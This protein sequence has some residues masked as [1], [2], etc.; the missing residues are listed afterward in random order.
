MVANAFSSKI[1][2]P[3]FLLSLHW[4]ILVET[5]ILFETSAPWKSETKKEESGETDCT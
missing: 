2:I 1:V 3:F 4:D 5:E